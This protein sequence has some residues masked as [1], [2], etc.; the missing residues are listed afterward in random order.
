V[1]KD[2]EVEH[3]GCIEVCVVF[4]MFI[5]LVFGLLIWW[6]YVNLIHPVKDVARRM[7]ELD[8]LQPS[9]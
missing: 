9:Q 3:N 1:L 6:L 8:P 2:L 4:L 7:R 5:V